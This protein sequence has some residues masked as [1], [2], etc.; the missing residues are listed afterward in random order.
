MFPRV[1]ARIHLPDGYGR[2]LGDFLYECDLRCRKM[3]SMFFIYIPISPICPGNSSSSRT[4]CYSS[5]CLSITPQKHLLREQ[6]I[7]FLCARFSFAK[8]ATTISSLLHLIV[9]FGSATPSQKSSFLLNMGRLV[10][11]PPVGWGRKDAMW[12]PSLGHK[13]FPHIT[14]T[15][16][17]KTPGG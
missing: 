15:C 3:K 16:I 2:L 11:V 9:W 6:A 17:H 14:S 12:L 1:Q 5:A 10:T 8:T 7:W 4:G 13:S